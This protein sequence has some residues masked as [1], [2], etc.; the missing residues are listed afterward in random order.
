VLYIEREFME[1]EKTKR[2]QLLDFL[3][4]RVFDPVLEALP[5]QYSSERDRRRLFEV[6]RI[7]EKKKERFHRQEL[8][9]A[10]IR[11]QYFREMFFE[12][13]GK[14]GRELEDLEL[15][16]LLELKEQFLKICQDLNVN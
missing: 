6:K 1:E 7:A 4:S 16:R 3:D 13:S 8:S 15:P 10:Q 11:E 2:R 12:T 9:A 5:E 14:I